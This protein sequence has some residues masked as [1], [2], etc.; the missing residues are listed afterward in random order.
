M[1]FN[2][3]SLRQIRILRFLDCS[4]QLRDAVANC[5][6]VVIQSGEGAIHISCHIIS[7]SVTNLLGK[8]LHCG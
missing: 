6:D 2:G 3:W 1:R 5:I 4:S 8:L 7:A